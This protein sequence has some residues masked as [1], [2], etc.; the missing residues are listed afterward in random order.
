M[1]L[2]KH[3]IEYLLY[4]MALTLVFGVAMMFVAYVAIMIFGEYG[5]QFI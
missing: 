3:T 5:V 4:V 2:I 1:I